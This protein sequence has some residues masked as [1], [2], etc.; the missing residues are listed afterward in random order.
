MPELCVVL[1]ERDVLRVEGGDEVV[2]VSLRGGQSD[3]GEAEGGVQGNEAAVLAHGERELVLEG[4]LERE[5]A[6]C[7]ARGLPLEERSLA[8]GCGLAVR[9]AVVGEDGAGA[10]R[11]GEG[12]ERVE[13]GDDPDLAHGSHALDWLELVEGVH[14]LNADGQADAAL[15]PA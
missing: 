9:P 14:G 1:L 6:L 13:V 2:D 12:P 10:R 5:V 15:E 3:G 11:V 7:E 4:D 8:D